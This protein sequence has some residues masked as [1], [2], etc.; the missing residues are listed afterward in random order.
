[1]EDAINKLHRLQ[2]IQQEQSRDRMRAESVGRLKKIITRKLQTSFIGAISEFELAFGDEWGHGLPEE[3]LTDIQKARRDKWEQVRTNIL[4]RGNAQ[5]RA[6]DAELD[7]HS[8]QFVGYRTIFGG[9]K[10]NVK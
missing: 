4:N 10:G 8:I 6:L 2:K 9:E 5:I 1:M 3:Q 7:L